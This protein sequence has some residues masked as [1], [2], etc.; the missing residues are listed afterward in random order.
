MQPEASIRSVSVSPWLL[1]AVSILAE[2][3]GTVALRVSEGFT[4][5][6]PSTL[7]VVAY[8]FTF[9][10]LAVT[11]REL[12]LG[13]VYAIWAGAGT[14]LVAVIGTV[15]FGEAISGLKVVSLALV[16]AGIVGLNLSGSQ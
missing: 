15:A 8:L 2:V 13:L 3:V 9:Y 4:R 14:A 16:V 1:L 11:V 6:V 5:P 10:G 12:P 7:C